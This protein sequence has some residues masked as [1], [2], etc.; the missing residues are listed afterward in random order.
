MI[1]TDII[2]IPMVWKVLGAGCALTIF[3]YSTFAT[4]DYVNA[5]HKEGI[6]VLQDIRNRVM[7]IENHL[8]KHN[9]GE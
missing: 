3:L 4:M 7:R 2:E 8:L 9:T 6:T 5:K 1:D